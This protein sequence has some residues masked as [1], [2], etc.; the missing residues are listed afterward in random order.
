MVWEIFRGI[1]QL[2]GYPENPLGES[3]GDVEAVWT[4]GHSRLVS[5]ENAVPPCVWRAGGM[6]TKSARVS[7]TQLGVL[8]TTENLLNA[9]GYYCIPHVFLPG[10][11]LC[12]LY[13]CLLI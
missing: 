7:I 9:P 3:G 2:S 4:L 12:Y 10:W 1:L 13:H 8:K 11:L 6:F 5:R